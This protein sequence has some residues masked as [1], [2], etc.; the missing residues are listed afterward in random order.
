MGFRAQALEILEIMKI[1]MVSPIRCSRGKT[2]GHAGA[3]YARDRNGTLRIPPFFVGCSR[4]DPGKFQLRPGLCPGYD[5]DAPA[6]WT[7]PSPRRELRLPRGLTDLP[8]RV[9]FRPFIILHIC[10]EWKR[11]TRP[12]IVHSRI[13]PAP[14]PA[15]GA[16]PGRSRDVRSRGVA[17][18]QQSNLRH[19]TTPRLQMGV[20]CHTGLY[21]LLTAFA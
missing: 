17:F 12:D 1:Q 20:P 5:F 13:H 19:F 6:S 7:T 14:K 8:Q 2:P 16:D 15:H 4:L 18:P 9:I 10:H 11:P 3:A 21:P